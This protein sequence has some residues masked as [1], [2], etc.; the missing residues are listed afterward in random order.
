M[1]VDKRDLP[2]EPNVCPI[3]L[4]KRDLPKEPYLYP[5]YVDKRNIPKEPYESIFRQIRPGHAS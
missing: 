1:S 2:K 5:A 4:N 3:L